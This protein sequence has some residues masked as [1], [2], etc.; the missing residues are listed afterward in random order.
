MEKKYPIVL[1]LLFSFICFRG[2]PTTA[3]Q[4]HISFTALSNALEAGNRELFHEEMK[5]LLLQR[6]F[7]EFMEVMEST[8][9][10]GETIFHGFARV[11]QNKVGFAT[12]LHTLLE[13]LSLPME[14]KS[15]SKTYTLAGTKISLSSLGKTPLA[16]AL[17]AGDLSSAAREAD[18]LLKGPAI[19]ALS[20]IHG[21]TSSGK[22]IYGLLKKAFKTHG[23]KEQWDK[24]QDLINEA[25]EAFTN[26]PLQ[27]NN[28]GLEPIEIV[29]KEKNKRIYEV[30]NERKPVHEVNN[31]KRKKTRQG[32]GFLAAVWAAWWVTGFDMSEILTVFVAGTIGAGIGDKCYDAI[33]YFI[34][35]KE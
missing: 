20:V 25:Q 9:H 28:A 29:D 32:I 34:S 26:L 23:T 31:G 22:T 19:D 33:Q 11:K 7:E 18:K 16:Q 30:L 24:I 14:S 2:N 10:S 13:L 8:T 6:S 12:D 21:T 4:A 5:K 27:E 17:K 15:A 1:I 35:R 3:S